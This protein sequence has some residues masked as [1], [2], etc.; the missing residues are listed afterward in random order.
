[1]IKLLATICFLLLSLPVLASEQAVSC[2]EAEAR[3]LGYYEALRN[4]DVEAVRNRLGGQ[5]AEK[6]RHLLTNPTYPEYLIQTYS[7]RREEIKDC[8][9]G[10]SDTVRVRVTETSFG[11]STDSVEKLFV[12]V[13]HAQT[14]DY[15][16]VS[17]GLALYD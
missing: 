4:G 8:A 11:P 2:A 14:G 13:R 1:M 17:E 6:R 10:N 5:L 15:L 7:D 9:P 3:V 16:I 12:L